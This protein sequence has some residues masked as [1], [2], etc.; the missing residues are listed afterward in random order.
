MT[1]GQLP[2]PRPGRDLPNGR[3]HV[4]ARQPMLICSAGCD[5]EYSANP[6]DYW[7]TPKTEVIT[8]G[9]C[10]EPMRLVD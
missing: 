2:S 4:K 1:Y 7:L 9:E 8:C 6:G 5:G 10:G 3:G